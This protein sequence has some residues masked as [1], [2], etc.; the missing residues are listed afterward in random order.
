MGPCRYDIYNWS[1]D[2]AASS[3][4]CVVDFNVVPIPI[5][6]W[7][8]LLN[9]INFVH[10]KRKG[11]KPTTHNVRTALTCFCRVSFRIA[12]QL[13]IHNALLSLYYCGNIYF[14]IRQK[15]YVPRTIFLF[16]GLILILCTEYYNGDRFLMVL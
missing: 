3:T 7:L 4:R 6:Y 15:K 14:Y 10:G 11:F 2:I 16:N 9:F 5:I 8:Y 13:E 1:D 12:I